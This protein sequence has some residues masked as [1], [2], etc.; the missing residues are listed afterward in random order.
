MNVQLSPRTVQVIN[1][2][3]VCTSRKQMATMLN[4]T[5]ESVSKTVSRLGLP[6]FGHRTVHKGTRVEQQVREFW[7]EN[8]S[9]KS[10]AADL[11]LTRGQVA[12]ILNRA[13]LFGKRQPKKAATPRRRRSAQTNIKGPKCNPIKFKPRAVS[14][15]PLH[16]SFASLNADSCRYPYG[17]GPFTF[18]GHVRFAGSSYCESHSFLCEQVPTPH[19]RAHLPRGRA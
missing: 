19:V 4:M 6:G 8:A 17:D 9:A 10:I 5:V 14:V 3:A 15:D 11:N 2:R 7:E 1:A 18:C 12:G 13:G 16:I